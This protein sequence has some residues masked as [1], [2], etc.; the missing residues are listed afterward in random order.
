MEAIGGPPGERRLNSNN[1][2]N[3]KT[4]RFI[5]FSTARFRMVEIERLSVTAFENNARV[6]AASKHAKT[7]SN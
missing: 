1:V 5:A 4:D 3:G 2:N 6:C 7:H